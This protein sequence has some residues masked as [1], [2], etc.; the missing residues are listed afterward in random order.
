MG[1]TVMLLAATSIVLYSIVALLSGYFFWQLKR[2]ANSYSR[3]GGSSEIGRF[4]PPKRNFFFVL[5]ISAILDLP[6]YFGCLANGGPK[7]CEWDD[8]SYPIFWCFHLVA[9][10]GYTFSVVTPPVLWIDIINHK[11]GLLFTSSFEVTYTKRFF[12]FAVVAFSIIM[13]INIILVS[14]FFNVSD[15]QDFASSNMLNATGTFLEPIFIFLVTCGCLWSGIKLQLYVRKVKLDSAKELRFLFHLNITMSII[16]LTYLTRGIFVLRLFYGMPDWYV[17]KLGCSYVAWLVYTRW[18]PYIFLSLC[19]INEMRISGS[20][21]SGDANPKTSLMRR[22][23]HSNTSSFF[24]VYSSFVAKNDYARMGLNNDLDVGDDFAGVSKSLLGSVRE[25]DT[26]LGG[27]YG[28]RNNS[29]THSS[30]EYPAS[31]SVSSRDDDME[32]FSFVGAHMGYDAG[33]MGALGT[34]TGL[35]SSDLQRSENSSVRSTEETTG[36]AASSSPLYSMD[37]LISPGSVLHA[38]RRGSEDTTAL[39]ASNNQQL[40]QQPR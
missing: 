21:S 38:L 2:K 22:A 8:V 14:L 28:G 18:L 37:S 32:P 13:L 6:I 1:L 27:S 4:D 26:L 39:V 40:P 19:L 5:C 24:S 34:S 3:I 33:R 10:C 15:P 30:L 16:V 31:K 35:G 25:E 23:E 12:Q 9:L 36:Y 29:N 17:N 20:N 11:D 7:D